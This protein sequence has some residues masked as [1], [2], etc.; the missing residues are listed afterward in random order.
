MRCA[1][2]VG[3]RCGGSA[4]AHGSCCFAGNDEQG[5]GGGTRDA[6]VVEVKGSC[7]GASISLSSSL[8]CSPS[9]LSPDPCSPPPV[10][11]AG[12]TTPLSN[13]L[14]PWDHK[15]VSSIHDQVLGADERHPDGNGGSR[16]LH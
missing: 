12:H 9:L 4:A 10:K 7:T 2:T 5:E 14:R 6:T 16:D 11:F 1:A 15:L 3:S 13:S 8:P